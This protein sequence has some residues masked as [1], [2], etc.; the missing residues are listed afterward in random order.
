MIDKFIQPSINQ[1]AQGAPYERKLTSADSP[2]TMVRRMWVFTCLETVPAVLTIALLTQFIYLFEK[3]PVPIA[4]RTAHVSYLY[5][6]REVNKVFP[7]KVPFYAHCIS[8]NL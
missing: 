5:S 7:I 1:Y 3:Y 8:Y 6:P 4:P 2:L